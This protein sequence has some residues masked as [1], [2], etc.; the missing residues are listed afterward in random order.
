MGND[1]W[2]NPSPSDLSYFGESISI[3][4]ADPSPSPPKS[5]VEQ[6]I[7]EK[8]GYWYATSSLLSYV[9]RHNIGIPKEFE[10][11]TWA[12]WQSPTSRH[13]DLIGK[14]K[15]WCATKDSTGRHHGL[16]LTGPTG[17]G[18]TMLGCLVLKDFCETMSPRFIDYRKITDELKYFQRD[19]NPIE[20]WSSV[21]FL[22]VDDLFSN[23]ESDAIVQK[24]G[25]MLT[26]RIN[27][28][29]PTIL[30]SNYRFPDEWSKHLDDRLISRLRYF[31]DE[32]QSHPVGKLE[33]LPDYRKTKRMLP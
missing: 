7:Y 23:S 4:N 27:E 33:A 32:I 11:Q 19:E 8:D 28:F 1:H 9:R 2:R 26:L 31:Y 20:D 10:V 21:D 14:V 5:W 29:A 6:Q 24:F 30:T 13:H 22:M 12:S 15:S 25:T 18:K 17:I 16:I 3:S